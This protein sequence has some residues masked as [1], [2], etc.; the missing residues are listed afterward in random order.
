M[1]IIITERQY[2]LLEMNSSIKRRLK[3][4]EIFLNNLM[5]TMYPCDYDDEY[6]FMS[7]RNG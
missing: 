5:E 6:S 7:A 3:G 2:Q 4:I 1:K